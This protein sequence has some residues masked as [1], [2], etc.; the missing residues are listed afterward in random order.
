MGHDSAAEKSIDAV[1]RTIEELVRND[2]IQGLV[3]F[4]QRTHGRDRDDS[5]DSQLFESVNVRAEIQFAGKNAVSAGVAGQECDFATFKSAAN[6]SVGGRAKRRFQAYFFYLTQ[7]GHGVKAA[8]ADNAYFRLCHLS[9]KSCARAE[10]LARLGQT[11]DYSKAMFTILAYW[12]A[13]LND[14]LQSLYAIF[15]LDRAYCAD[16]CSDAGCGSERPTSPRCA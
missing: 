8:A 10:L 4:L 13:S 1:A 9:S 16:A 14:T 12:V 15:V 5:I 6:I 11:H 7:A 2:E 3:F